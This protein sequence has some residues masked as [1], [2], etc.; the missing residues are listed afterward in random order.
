VSAD[1][2][3]GRPEHSG[4]KPG[5]PSPG[6][7]DGIGH[8]Q[9]LGRGLATGVANPV[10]RVSRGKVRGTFHNRKESRHVFSRVNGPNVP[11]G[12]RERHPAKARE[13]P[14]ITLN[15]EWYEE[16]KE[17]KNLGRKGF[18]VHFFSQEPKSGKT[19]VSQVHSEG[20][21]AKTV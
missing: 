21:Q 10:G 16:K 15:N 4:D 6:G 12:S 7:H 1:T 18:C 3:K 5:I 9:V 19:S 20:V 13:H 17:R 14:T 11:T 2:K 8:H